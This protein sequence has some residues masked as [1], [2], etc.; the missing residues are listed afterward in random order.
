MIFYSFCNYYLSSIQ[1]GIQSAHAMH[2][3]FTKY[4]GGPGLQ[5][6]QMLDEWAKRH[7]T[8][9]VL[10]G[11]NVADLKGLEASCKFYGDTLRYPYSSFRED[12]ESLNGALTAVAI[13]V[14]EKLFLYNQERRKRP[15]SS[16]DLYSAATT[17]AMLQNKFQMTDTE[18]E[19]ANLISTCPLAR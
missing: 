17:L 14:P 5:E 7:K 18:V 12:A 6:Q 11:G 19:L 15:P 8:M 16:V 13:I 2:T 1:Q 4:I 3:M 10:N 9:I